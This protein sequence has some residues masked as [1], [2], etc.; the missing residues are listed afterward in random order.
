[1]TVLC[2][3]SFN[4]SSAY[5]CT[6]VLRRA[7]DMV[8]DVGRECA[9]QFVGR[10]LLSLSLRGLE[11]A[12]VGNRSSSLLNQQ[13]GT[14]SD[15]APGAA[16]AGVGAGAPTSCP[17]GRALPALMGRVNNG[18]SPS[19][20]ATA[21]ASTRQKVISKKGTSAPIMYLSILSVLVTS[22]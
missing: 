4:L 8:S 3:S 7:S 19:Q 1:M 10:Q 11:A 9:L 13:M 6:K 22:T 2:T 5:C 20:I 21:S 18:P 14:S 16:A 17:M 12:A 15:I